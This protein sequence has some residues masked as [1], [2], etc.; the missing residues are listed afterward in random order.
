[1]IRDSRYTRGYVPPMMSPA[2]GGDACAGA[3]RPKGGRDLSKC[4]TCSMGYGII[5][6]CSPPVDMR[7]TGIK[8]FGGER[9]TT[10][11]L[12][13]GHPAGQFQQVKAVGSAL[14]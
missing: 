3:S 9:G 2:G 1:M 14:V 4:L 10:A 13:Y 6:S 11:Y 7:N 5:R 12:R 8:V